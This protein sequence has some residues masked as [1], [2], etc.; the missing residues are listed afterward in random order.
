MVDDEVLEK[1]VK[2]G[3]KQ[4]IKKRGRNSRMDKIT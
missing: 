4:P 1:L 2:L 3:Y